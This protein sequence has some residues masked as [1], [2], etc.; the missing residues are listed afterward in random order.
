MSSG[1]AVSVLVRTKNRPAFLELS[2]RSVV[3][4]TFDDLEVVVVED[5]GEPVARRVVDRAGDPRIA[6]IRNDVS[7]GVGRASRVALE[8]ARGRYVAF[9]DDD[10]L[11]DRGFLDALVPA[12]ER[13]RTIVVAFCRRRI[14][15]VDGREIAAGDWRH[16]ED[17][18]DWPTHP[19][20]IQPFVHEALVSPVVHTAQ[21]AVLRREAVE[22]SL[23]GEAM[24]SAWDS[25]VNYA[26]CRE[27][28]AA[29]F[30]P[31]VL[32]SY[33]VHDVS[34]NATGGRTILSDRVETHRLYCA[35]ERL[36]PWHRKLRRGLSEHL[37]NRALSFTDAEDLRQSR[38]DVTEA[39]RTS[40]SLRALRALPF[41]LLPH[42]AARRATDAVRRRWHRRGP[43]PGPAATPGA[44]AA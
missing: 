23:L 7:L 10:D 36:A 43:A 41:V 12:L 27:G 15:D 14:I 39:L 21:S 13:D 11:W 3:A 31:A 16:H 19:G 20:R 32:S 35:D 25:L 33:R 6:T 17:G 8:A 5:G 40:P 37:V 28:A 42:P 29:W 1:P 9:L 4:Q 18:L 24:S 30:E 34:M 2:L 22:V 38:R 44:S 26:A